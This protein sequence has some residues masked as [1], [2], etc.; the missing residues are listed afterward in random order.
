MTVVC[1]N[2]QKY[3]T[4]MGR[5]LGMAQATLPELYNLHSSRYTEIVQQGVWYMNT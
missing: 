3:A 1:H 2:T 5:F 4:E